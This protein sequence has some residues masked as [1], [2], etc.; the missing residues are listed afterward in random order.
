MSGFSGE[1]LTAREPVDHAARSE[2]LTGALAQML[3]GKGKVTLTDLG[4]GTGSTLRALSPILGRNVNWHLIDHDDAL[5]ELAREAAM[6]APVTF[7]KA[8][9]ATDLSPISTHSPHAVTTSA[10][11]DLVS[12][13]WLERLVVYLSK[14]DLPFYAALTYDGRAGCD[15]VHELDET[16]LDAFNAHQRTDKGFGKALGPDAAKSAIDL[17]KSASFTILE[18][19]SDWLGTPGHK[20]FQRMLLAGWRDAAVEIEPS[21]KTRFDGWLSDRLAAVE[22][23]A[24]CF[25]GHVDFLAIPPER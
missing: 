8:D 9:L 14:H 13:Q 15:P 1:W 3:D 18:E 21:R 19:R 11:L 23:N 20:A 7:T 4:A 2:V 5:L 24:T 17:F 6:G 10:F 25:V 12:H 22:E 16:V